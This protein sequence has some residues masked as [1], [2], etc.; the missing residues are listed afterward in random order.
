MKERP[1]SPPDH[2]DYTAAE[3]AD[4]ESAC[5]L[6]AE[7]EVERLLR[8]E[9][10]FHDAVAAFLVDDFTLILDACWALHSWRCESGL[11][12]EMPL[13]EVMEKISEIVDHVI[14]AEVERRYKKHELE[15]FL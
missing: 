11:L 14:A 10:N 6:R 8:D 7:N 15:Y 13:H 12:D 4:I 9:G 5:M 3:L 2:K 1:I